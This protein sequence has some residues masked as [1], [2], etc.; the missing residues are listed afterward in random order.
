MRASTSAEIA[1]V[2]TTDLRATEQHFP[3]WAEE[4]AVSIQDAG[5]WTTP[6]LVLDDIFA[7][8]DGHHRWNAAR[9]LGLPC[10]PAVIV[11]YDDPRLTL[12]SWRVDDPVTRDDVI[13]AALSGQLLPQKTSRHT[14]DPPLATA[15]VA[16][17][18][19]KSATAVITRKRRHKSTGTVH[20]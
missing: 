19:L 13:N 5:V 10:I 6:I 20:A 16:L 11:S 17:E 9:M 8:L 12:S 3:S 2:S 1:L 18:D 4:L 7:I 14:M 15:Y